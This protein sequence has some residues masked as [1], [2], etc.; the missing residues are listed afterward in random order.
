MIKQSPRIALIHDVFIEF[1]GA[2]RVLLEL[3]ALYPDA[4]IFIPLLQSS[5]RNLL[6]RYSRGKIYSSW[7][8]YVPFVHS[9]SIVIKPL[10]YLY[11]QFLDVSKY[12][13]VISSSHSF[14]SKGVITGP[15]TYHLSYV[16]TPPRYLY[17]EYNET[18]ILRFTLFRAILTPLLSWLR[19][20]DY[21]SA[22]R[23]DLLVA[24][25]KVVAQR[26]A[27]YYRRRAQIVY[28]PIRMQT[29]T[30]LKTAQQ[31]WSKVWHERVVAPLSSSRRQ[32]FASVKP[33]QYYVCFSRLS[34]Q[35]GIDL[36][37]KVCSQLGRPLVV[38][39][40]GAQA[41]YLRSLAGPT[42]TLIGS[43]SDDQKASLLTQARALLYCSIEEDFGMVTAEALA[44]GI[45]VV[46]YN[47]G[48]TTEIVTAKTGILFADFTP[49]SLRAAI[50]LFEGKRFSVAA[51]QSRA[52]IFA[53]DNFLNGIYKLVVKRRR[54]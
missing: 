5:K 13:V 45:P 44:H 43:V 22:Q 2:E 32:F 39:G 12:D 15:N 36:A 27:K 34:K 23:P 33:K 24:N 50:K 51:C 38:V 4:D 29:P 48:G 18:Q 14:S 11:W 8:N 17:V 16:H 7:L 19:M 35:K 9:A 10:L 6:A 25:S 21:L 52:R 40:E 53:A 1:G 47:S 31:L 54:E 41:S 37:V 42:V 20:H 49:E 46:G 28:P 30:A 3:V 26:I